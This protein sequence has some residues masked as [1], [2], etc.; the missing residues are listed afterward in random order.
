MFDNGIGGNS[1]SAELYMTESWPKTQRQIENPQKRSRLLLLSGRCWVCQRAVLNVSLNEGAD[2]S[3][4]PDKVL[5]YEVNS[6]WCID[7][8][9]HLLYEVNALFFWRSLGA[10]LAKDYSNSWD[11]EAV[12]LPAKTQLQGIDRKQGRWVGDC[13]LFLLLLLSKWFRR[14]RLWAQVSQGL[15]ISLFVSSSSSSFFLWR[16]D[17][18]L[19]H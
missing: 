13:V 15:S 2:G 9:T 5:V 8:I 14:I 11:W 16:W 4:P 1:R 17:F 7:L 12:M 19:N 6:F 18:V 3:P 10:A